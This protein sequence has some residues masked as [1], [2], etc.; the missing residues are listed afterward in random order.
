MKTSIS[1]H[2]PYSIIFVSDEDLSDPPEYRDRYIVANEEALTIPCAPEQDMPTRITLAS[3]SDD[4]PSDEPIFDGYI[5]TPQKRV[6]VTTALMDVVLRHSVASARTRVRVFTNDVS[7]PDN[8][9]I[10]VD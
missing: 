2:P 10:V 4:P 7:F 3:A 1:I 9:L 8:I 5:A 6:V